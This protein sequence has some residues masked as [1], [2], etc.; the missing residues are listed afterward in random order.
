MTRMHMVYEWEAEYAPWRNSSAVPLQQWSS[1]TPR[2]KKRLVDR[3]LW[4][5]LSTTE[6]MPRFQ[7]CLAGQARDLSLRVS[8][9][10]SPDLAQVRAAVTAE[11]AA[12]R[13]SVV[14]AV[15]WG[16][17]RY[18]K[19][20]WQYLERNLR[21]NGG[22]V[23]RVLAITLKR[24]RAEEF[25]KGAEL[26]AA[27]SSKYPREVTQTTFCSQPFGCA[28]D[29]ILVDPHVVYIK[30]DDDIIF[31]KD[32]SFE[33]LVYQTLFNDDYTFYSGSVVNNPHSYGV[34]KFAGA[35]PPMTYH[36][37]RLGTPSLRTKHPD[38][39]T[40]YY[41]KTLHDAVGSKAHEAFVYNV[42]LGRL[43][44]YAF[45]LWNMHQ[46]QCSHPQ[47]DLGMCLYGFYRW[48]IN[49]FSFVKNVTAQYS[50]RTPKFDEPTVS[51]GWVGA[52]APHRVAIV[53]ESLFVHCQVRDAV[54]T[55]A[56]LAALSCTSLSHRLSP[57]LSSTVH[58]AAN[59]P[60]R[61]RSSRRDSASLVQ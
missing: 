17:H 43:D 56:S 49:A 18:V 23:D 57:L 30:I 46:C 26:L 32:G 50:T 47:D 33:H 11:L 39:M 34:H 51:I 37:P 59:I 38:A 55:P 41:G 9:Y 25:S 5:S 12:R 44:V 2:P 15:F 16:R 40:D 24:D 48:S 36:W 13:A 22:V 20:L 7:Q 54:P 28:Y 53:G 19:I 58:K 45:D 35:L 21:S 61:L 31:I 14:V 4:Q 60:S 42:A 52:I 10:R 27:A 29:D 3:T 8:A 1:R 6:K